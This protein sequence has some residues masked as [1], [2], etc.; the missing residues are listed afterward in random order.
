MTNG[1][2][3]LETSWDEVIWSALTVGRPNLHYVFQHGDASLFEGLFRV[4]LVRMAM[5]QYG[6]GAFRFRRTA[7]AKA[8]DPT[9]KGSV[10][11]FLGMTFCKLIRRTTV[12][13]TLGVTR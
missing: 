12:R 6:D 13:H 8:L 11:Y 5:E 4:S 10:N 3:E 7:A 2:H 9:E 1:W